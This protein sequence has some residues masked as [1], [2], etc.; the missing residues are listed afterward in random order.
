MPPV[1]PGLSQGQTGLPLCKIRR[2]PGFVPGTEWVCPRDKSGL[3]WDNPG[4]VP[5]AILSQ[6]MRYINFVLGTPKWGVLGI[7]QNVCVENVSVLSLSLSKSPSHKRFRRKS[8]F[9]A[10]SLQNQIAIASDG[11]SRWDAVDLGNCPK[12]KSSRKWLGE[13]AKGLLDPA[14]KR[15]LALVRNGVAPVQKRVWETFAPWAQKVS[16]RQI[17]S[18]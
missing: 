15:P 1:V 14:S 16:E 17:S 6:E 18:D 10:R 4:V 12:S 3:S 2:K 5:R 7:G 8:A 13:G 11:N 9:F